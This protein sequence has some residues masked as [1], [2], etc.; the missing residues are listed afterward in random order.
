MGC[1][2]F[3]VGISLEIRCGSVTMPGEGIVVA[4]GKAI[5]IPFAKAKVMVD[6]TLIVIA[7]VCGYLSK[8][9][10]KRIKNTDT[11]SFTHSQLAGRYS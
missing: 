5:N 11:T 2:L 4:V 10:V 6:I 1:V 7:L 9:C 3:A 8:R